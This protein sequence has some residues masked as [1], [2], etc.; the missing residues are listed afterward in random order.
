MKVIELVAANKLPVKLS[1]TPDF[2]DSVD[3]NGQSHPNDR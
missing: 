2:S 3:G 1:A